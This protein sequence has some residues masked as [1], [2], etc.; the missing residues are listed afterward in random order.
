MHKITI[1]IFLAIYSPKL[2]KLISPNDYIQERYREALE[3]V[4]RLSSDTTENAFA[5]EMSYLNITR[6]MP[7]LLDRNDRMSGAA[8]LKIR[9]PF[10]DYKLIEYLWNV[11]WEYK[12]HADREKGLLRK[13]LADLLPEDVLWRKKSPYPKTHNP[14]YLNTVRGLLMNVLE[15]KNSPLLEFIEKDKIKEFAMSMA[16]Q[17]NIP[18]FGQLMNAPQMLAYFVQ[19]NEWLERYKVEILW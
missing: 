3:E 5:R 13:A 15:D 7:T 2:L 14:E 4:P 19:V 12:F 11:P 10:C 9:T 1:D 17:T 6:W 8:N 16:P 18:W